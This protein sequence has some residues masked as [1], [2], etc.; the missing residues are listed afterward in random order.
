MECAKNSMS[1]KTDME[2]EGYTRCL[3][4]QDPIA[5]SYPQ[6]LTRCG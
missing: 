2:N 1:A 4:K 5:G 3:F 6:G